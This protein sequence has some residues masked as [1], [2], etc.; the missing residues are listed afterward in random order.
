M[1]WR[2]LSGWHAVL[3]SGVHAGC[4]PNVSRRESRLWLIDIAGWGVVVWVLRIELRVEMRGT[5]EQILVV[6]FV[7]EGL[8][9]LLVILRSL[10]RC[11]D[12]HH[13]K[14]GV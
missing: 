5:R 11:C 7:E 10:T 4:I 13:C 12:G 14:V 9:E 6:P 2:R 1:E 8:I 3:W